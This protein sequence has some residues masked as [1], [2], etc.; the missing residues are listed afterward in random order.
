[1]SLTL[2]M[3]QQN[4]GQFVVTLKEQ[5]LYIKKN[6][7]GFT[8][9]IDTR[10]VCLTGVGKAKLTMLLTPAWHRIKLITLRILEKN[11]NLFWACLQGPVG[12]V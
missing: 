8:S 6:K 10:K 2:A 3:H 7:Y 1:V 12:A 9:V 11:Q 5:S 4:F